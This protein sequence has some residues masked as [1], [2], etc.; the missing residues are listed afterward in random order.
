M[1]TVQ[2]IAVPSLGVDLPSIIDLW[3][4]IEVKRA[5]SGTHKAVILARGLGTRMRA[6]SPGS[7]LK[8]DQAS[9]ADTGVKA[10]IPIGRPFIDYVLSSL[11]DAGFADVCLVIGPEHSQIRNYYGKE[12]RLTRIRIEFAEQVEPLGTADAV[13]AAEKFAAGDT[14]VVLNS[15]NYYPPPVLADLQRLRE[16]AVIA[17]ARSALMELGNVSADR[18]TRFGALDIGE[19]GYL[20]RILAR[21]DDAMVRQG[22]EIYASMNCWLFDS[23]IFRACREVSPSPRGELELPR[24]VQLAIDRHGMKMRVIKVRSQVLDLSSRSDIAVVEERLR[25]V[26]VSL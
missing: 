15:D 2:D 11:A 5:I 4:R 21:P 9:V 10:M 25:G 7:S 16:P 12:A 19:D 6:E 18:V 26:P 3:G 22:G 20:R 1:C 24:A 23:G 14:F 8:A 13:L 17:F